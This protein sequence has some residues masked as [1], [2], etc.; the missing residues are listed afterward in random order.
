MVA[1]TATAARPRRRASGYGEADSIQPL[2]SFHTHGNILLEPSMNHSGQRESSSGDHRRRGALHLRSFSVDCTMAI[3]FSSSDRITS[4]YF[5]FDFHWTNHQDDY[6]KFVL[7]Y[8]S[9]NFCYRDLG[10]WFTRSSKFGSKVDPMQLA[11]WF[12]TRTRLTT[13]LLG[14]FVPIFV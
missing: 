9:L 8:I 3:S 1:T 13:Q 14:R 12:H 6:T 5:F 4:G 11:V 10:Q 7:L 2:W